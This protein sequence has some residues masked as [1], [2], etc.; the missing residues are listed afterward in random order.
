[1]TV[2]S[3]EIGHVTFSFHGQNNCFEMSANG[4]TF[5]NGKS[6]EKYMRLLIVDDI[7][8]G[9]GNVSTEHYPGYFR[10]IGSKY[11]VSGV[12]VLNVW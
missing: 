6:I 7:L 1:M 8:S 9:G 3:Y 2:S 4:R 5:H 11:K 12:T 10:A